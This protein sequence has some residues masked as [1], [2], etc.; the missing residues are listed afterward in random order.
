M[1]GRPRDSLVSSD[2]R[3]LCHSGGRFPPP[4]HACWGVPLP[5]LAA[6][7]L[8]QRG[9]ESTSVSGDSKPRVYIC[10][11]PRHLQCFS[12]VQTSGVGYSGV[13][14]A[15]VALN[16]AAA[17]WSSVPVLGLFAVPSL[18]YPF[19]MLALNQVIIPRASFVGHLAGIVAG[20]AAAAGALDL[21]PYWFW[22]TAAY[23]C[24][25]AALSV[26]A[27][28]AVAAGGRLDCIALSPA[29]T[30]ATG[31]GGAAEGDPH[32]AQAGPRRYVSAGGVLRAGPAALLDAQVRSTL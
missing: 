28:P 18:L 6:G 21:S 5:H 4:Y 19:A 17:P 20:F 3:R 8:A 22:T 24:V 13:V 7:E 32:A 11:G 12:P 2:H 9:G 26:K 25:A 30:R 27:N 1:G 31:L 10:L 15:W 14:Y 29:L 16:A 23:F